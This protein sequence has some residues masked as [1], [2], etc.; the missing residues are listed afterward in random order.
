MAEDPELIPSCIEIIG[1]SK[2]LE[3]VGDLAMN[4]SDHAIDLAEGPS[5]VPP[6]VRGFTRS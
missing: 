2:N 4:I 1:V 6:A 3:R 5:R